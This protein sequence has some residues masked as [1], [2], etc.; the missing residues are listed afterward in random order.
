MIHMLETQGKNA[1]K[2]LQSSGVYGGD[3]W[4][5]EG[6]T[7]RKMTCTRQEEGE[8]AENQ[9]G[10]CMVKHICRQSKID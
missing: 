8:N 10:Q 2:L 6:E 5:D 1:S 9:G 3:S 7:M 4:F